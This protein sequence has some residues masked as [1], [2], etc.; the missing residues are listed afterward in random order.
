[1]VFLQN[2]VLELAEE[3]RVLSVYHAAGVWGGGL[4]L[5]GRHGGVVA[6]AVHAGGSVN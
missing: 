4:L 1:M 3:C 6:G 2:E 5:A